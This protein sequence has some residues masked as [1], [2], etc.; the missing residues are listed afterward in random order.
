MN[1]IKFTFEVKAGRSTLGSCQVEAETAD[2][3][4]ALYREVLEKFS[5]EPAPAAAKAPKAAPQKNEAPA[6]PSEQPAAQPTPISGKREQKDF[7]LRLNQEALKWADRAKL[8]IPDLAGLEVPDILERF[9]PSKTPPAAMT[10]SNADHLVKA[11]RGTVHTYAVAHPEASAF[12]EI[13]EMLETAP[14]VEEMDRR[15]DPKSE[16]GFKKWKVLSANAPL[17]EAAKK[18]YEDRKVLLDSSNLVETLVS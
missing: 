17:F 13:A 3:A 12:L 1:N 11:V 14:S 9:N 16:G 6:G 10:V 7:L 15:K 8:I 18:I 4:V 2:A 5:G